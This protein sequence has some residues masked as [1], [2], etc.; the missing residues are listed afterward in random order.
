L[1]RPEARLGLLGLLKVKNWTQKRLRITKERQTDPAALDLAENIILDLVPS[2]DWACSAVTIFSAVS[3]K[4]FRDKCV[5][6]S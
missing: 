3:A 4:R 1:Q 6:F 5:I 2:P